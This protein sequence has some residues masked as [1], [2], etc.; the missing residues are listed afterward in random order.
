MVERTQRMVSMPSKDYPL[1]ISPERIGLLAKIL[2]R[3]GF[4]L[5]VYTDYTFRRPTDIYLA[6]CS[7]HRIYFLD[8]KHGYDEYVS[9]PICLKEWLESDP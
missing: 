9:C 1:E 4:I 5:K 7:K 6:Y 3:L 8:Y 2:A